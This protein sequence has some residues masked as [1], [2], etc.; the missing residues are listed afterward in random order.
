MSAGK[1]DRGQVVPRPRGRR[2]QVQ[3]PR[4]GTGR[5]SRPGQ[6]RCSSPAGADEQCRQ[7]EHDRDRDHD[8]HHRRRYCDGEGGDDPGD[9]RPPDPL[10]RRQVED[11]LDQVDRHRRWIGRAD[12]DGETQQMHEPRDSGERD[13]GAQPTGRDHAGQQRHRH[14]RDEGDRALT[15]GREQTGEAPDPEP[16]EEHEPDHGHG[17]PE[18]HVEQ[19]QHAGRGHDGE[20]GRVGRGRSE[21]RRVPGRRVIP[22]QLAGAVRVFQELADRGH[23]S[24]D[25]RPARH[26]NRDDD[27]A[28]C[29]HGRQ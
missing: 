2:R 20:S 28:P 19:P 18:A 16:A 27:D 24:V 7:R 5:E 8:Q 17:Q 23:G 10:A 1:R 29:D 4:H 6:P 15:V 11:A 3:H 21:P 14:V 25:E 13:Q 9:G 12:A 22:P 26:E